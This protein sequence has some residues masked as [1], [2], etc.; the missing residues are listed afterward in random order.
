M[1]PVRLLDAKTT[2]LVGYDDLTKDD[3]DNPT[4][5]PPYAIL[6]HRWR[7]REVVFK[8]LNGWNPVAVKDLPDSPSRTKLLKACE[9]AQRRSPS[10]NY[11]W[12]DTVCIDKSDSPELQEAMNSM[13]KYY[14]K[15]EVCYAFLDD[16]LVSTGLSKSTNEKRAGKPSEWFERGWT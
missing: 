4:P 5:Y 10:I 7:G 16:V 1:P 13:F 15:A 12:A 3:N 6:S 2:Q 11:L 14:G 9:Q 8:D